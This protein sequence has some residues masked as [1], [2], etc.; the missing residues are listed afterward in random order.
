MHD[1]K[2]VTEDCPKGALIVVTLKSLKDVVLS[3]EPK[4][5]GPVLF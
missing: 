2:K 4:N 1:E 3:V 5:H